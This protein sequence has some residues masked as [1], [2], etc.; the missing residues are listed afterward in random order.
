MK[1]ILLII[2]L[3]FTTLNISSQENKIVEGRFNPVTSFIDYSEFLEDVDEAPEIIKINLELYLKVILGD[4]F[5]K[6]TFYEGLIVDLDGYFKENPLAY[7]R[8]WLAT[9][10]QFVYLLSDENIGISKYYIKID[11]DQYGQI[12]NCNW[13]SKDF[14]YTYSFDEKTTTPFQNDFQ[15]N[16]LMFENALKWAE[17]NFITT[18]KYS[19]ELTFN[20]EENTMCFTFKFLIEKKRN[21]KTFRIAEFNW[22]NGLKVA[23]YTIM[24]T[25]VY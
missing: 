10:Y 14:N 17:D 7:K 25:T 16:E 8:G 6:V 24:E 22:L 13:P 4:W 19:V 21:R 9:K 15:S 5:D 20:K 11:M 3:T 1:R 23:D 2:I 18:D 12:I